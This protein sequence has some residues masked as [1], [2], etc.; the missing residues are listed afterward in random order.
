MLRA[1]EQNGRIV[2]LRLLLLFTLLPLVEL[3]LLLAIAQHTD[4]QFALGLVILTGVVG[5]W[6]ARREGLRC[7]RAVHERLHAG[8]L[9]TDSLLDGLLILVAGALLITPGIITDLVG[10]FLLVQPCRRLMKRWLMRRFQVHWIVSPPGESDSARYSRDE[11]IDVRVID[12]KRRD[13]DDGR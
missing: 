12:P 1:V 4:W 10:F 13:E 6:L 11:V 8:Q 7:W 2:L 5:A 9:P 3:A